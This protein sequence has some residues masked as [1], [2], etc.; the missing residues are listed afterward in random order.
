MMIIMFLYLVSKVINGQQIKRPE[1]VS[2]TTSMKAKR[3]KIS[4]KLI[5]V[6][7]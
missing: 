1:T 4:D 7:R 3:L 6:Y 5:M 2:K